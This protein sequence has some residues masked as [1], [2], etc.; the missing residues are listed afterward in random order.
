VGSVDSKETTLL[1]PGPIS[2]IALGDRELFYRRG[3]DLVAQPFDPRDAKLSG[4]ARV[5]SNHVSIV[6]AAG[7]TLVYFDP[8]GG[9]SEG[10]RITMFSRTGV[11]LSHVGDV[12]TFWD[13]KLSPDGRF[14]AVARAG[15]TGLFSIWTYDL[16]RNIDSRVT[17]ATFAS[18]AWTRDSRSIV[19][20]TSGRSLLRFDL[21]AGG[22]PHVIHPLAGPAGVVDTSPDG[23]DALIE[24]AGRDTMQLGPLRWTASPIR[25]RS[26]RRSRS[27]TRR[28]RSL[29]TADGLPSWPGK[30]R[31]GGCSCSPT[32]DPARA[33]R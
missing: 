6:A 33:S 18:P 17:G 20:G 23:R 19:V 7:G 4:Q 27:S 31:R 14:V 2:E 16:A 10:H 21:G 26:A 29:P 5:L 11:V 8:P 1:V 25:A 28:P 32:R 30:G 15:E 13:P 3:T 22:P 24:I 9:L 12:G